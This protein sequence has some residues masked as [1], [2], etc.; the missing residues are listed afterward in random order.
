MRQWN[1][2]SC[3][4][5]LHG[6][7]VTCCRHRSASSWVHRC[8]PTTRHA[9]PPSPPDLASALSPLGPHARRSRKNFMARQFSCGHVRSPNLVLQRPVKRTPILTQPSLLFPAAPDASRAFHTLP[10]PTSPHRPSSTFSPPQRKQA[11]K[12]SRTGESHPTPPFAAALAAPRARAS[13]PLTPSAHPRSRQC[14]R[15]PSRTPTPPRS[16]PTP[17]PRPRPRPTSPCPST[18]RTRRT[19]PRGRRRCP[20]TTPSTL[21]PRSRR[22]AGINCTLS[23]DHFHF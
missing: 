5:S 10:R 16:S 13:G 12:R 18:S 11:S 15:S 9:P 1:E 20:R 2:L 14:R 7:H 4:C 8:C 17:P 19:P 21:C 23:L 22:Y 6:R 3:D